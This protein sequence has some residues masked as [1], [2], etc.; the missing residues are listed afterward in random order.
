MQE[1]CVLQ[2]SGQT[3]PPA[4][5]E[6]AGSEGVHASVRPVWSTRSA[7]TRAPMKE[8]MPSV[9]LPP[10]KKPLEERALAKLD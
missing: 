8:G 6:V 2:P 10:T 9:S 5:N 1:P 7:D 3:V 4:T